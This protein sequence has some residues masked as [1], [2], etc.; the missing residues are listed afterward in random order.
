MLCRS[1]RISWPFV[2]K[3]GDDQRHQRLGSKST[4]AVTC[5]DLRFRQCDII[6][7][8]PWVG[9]KVVGIWRW[10]TMLLTCF[11][12]EIDIKD[13]WQTYE[14]VP[15]WKF[16]EFLCWRVSAFVCPCTEDKE[17][18]KQPEIISRK[19]VF[20]RITFN[21]TLRS[22]LT[23]KSKIA[24]TRTWKDILTVNHESRINK[25][26]NHVSREKIASITLHA[27]STGDPL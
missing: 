8:S 4:C 27:K 17:V 2:K 9:F 20:S 1:L 11:R 25:S 13:N 23:L 6:Y 21:S 10:E 24:F 12:I 14:N 3:Y 26:L 16:E 22:Q 5:C 15:I 18:H 19:Q 7:G